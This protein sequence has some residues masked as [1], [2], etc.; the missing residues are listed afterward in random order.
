[1]GLGN[2]CVPILSELIL[3]IVGY[4]IFIS[5]MDFIGALY[6]RE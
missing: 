3:E 4:L 6:Y 1:M 2:T 5:Q